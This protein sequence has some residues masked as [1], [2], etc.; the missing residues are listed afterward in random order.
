MRDGGSSG[1]G[2]I[3]GESM[4][5]GKSMAGWDPWDADSGRELTLGL[6]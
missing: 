3:R 6:P 2:D 1:S 4:G 5:T